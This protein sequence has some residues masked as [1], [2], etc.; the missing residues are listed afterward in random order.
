MDAGHTL[1]DV[2]ERP[3]GSPVK[4][5]AARA[6]PIPR[7]WRWGLPPGRTE[8]GRWGRP[9]PPLAAALLPSLP[10]SLWQCPCQ[11]SYL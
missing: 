9:C 7:W 11:L 4:A 1:I 3:Q 6:D 2:C 5:E 8:G 10:C